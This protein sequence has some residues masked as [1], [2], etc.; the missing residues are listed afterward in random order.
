MTG[1][2]FILADG[3]ASRRHCEV[4]IRGIEVLVD[5]LNS[6]NGTYVNGAPVVAGQPCRLFHD[7]VLVVGTTGFRV[8]IRDPKTNQ[9]QTPH[10]CGLADPRSTMLGSGP[11]ANDESE[12]DGLVAQL[13]AMIS[14]LPVVR[15]KATEETMKESEFRSRREKSKVVSVEEPVKPAEETDKKLEGEGASSENAG[16][17]SKQTIVEEVDDGTKKLPKEFLERLKTKTSQEAATNA[18]GSLFGRR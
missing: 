14:K 17:P 8:S 11:A 9:P 3:R 10:A 6:R 2:D 4:V 15:S 18:L 16:K 7:D 5:D 12:L 1:G 13:D